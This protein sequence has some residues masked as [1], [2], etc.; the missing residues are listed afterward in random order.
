MQIQHDA[1]PPLVLGDDPR[2]LKQ[3]E[4]VVADEDIVP[5]DGLH[6]L[7]EL[8]LAPARD[9]QRAV[10]DERFEEIELGTNQLCRQPHSRP[11]L[12]W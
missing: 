7:T 12:F 9:L 1:L 4:I 10:G 2:T 8:V 5:V 3:A 11:L 6:Q